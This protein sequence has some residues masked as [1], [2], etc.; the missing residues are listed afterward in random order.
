MKYHVGDKVVFINNSKTI[1]EW[2]IT[3]YKIYKIY[4]Y[5]TH[6]SGV[7]YSVKFGSTI[8]SWYLECDF[9]SLIE[10]RKL[11]IEKLNNLK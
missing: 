6:T 7:V 5:S 10:Y 3:E 9:M 2:T 4:G 1:Y 8:Q 11:K